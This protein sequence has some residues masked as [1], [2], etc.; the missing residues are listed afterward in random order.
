MCASFHPTED[1]VISASLDQTVRIWDV[2]GL[3]K[4]VAPGPAALYDHSR[5]LQAPDLFGQVLIVYFVY[6]YFLKS[7]S[8]YLFLQ[9]DAVV[10]HV[11]EGHDRGVNWASFHPTLPL[12]AS[13]A[14]DRQV[15]LWRMNGSKVLIIFYA[16]EDITNT[17]NL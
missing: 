10:K 8:T 9:A 1:L 5:N 14:D 16:L 2:T 12:I 17:K 13:G 11:L 7:F 6:K 15:K 4:K 3:R